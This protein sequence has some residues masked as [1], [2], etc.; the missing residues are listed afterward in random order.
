MDDE[1][2]SPEFRI[3]AIRESG[4]RLLPNI[5]YSSLKFHLKSLDSGRETDERPPDILIGANERH[6]RIVSHTIYEP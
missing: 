4:N 3:A 6:Q 2:N 1:K 5:S